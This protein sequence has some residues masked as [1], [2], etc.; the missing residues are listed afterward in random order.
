M[1]S[2][3]DNMKLKKNFKGIGDTNPVYTQRY[4]ADPWALVYDGRVYLYMTGD[5]YIYDEKGEIQENHYGNIDTLNVISSADLVNWTDHGCV[6]AAGKN[7][8]AT[9]GGN[10][11]APA[12]AC[13]E[14]DGK[15]KF[16]L[17]FANSGNGIAVL[18]ADSPVGPFTDPIGGPLISR[19]KTPTCDSVTWLFDP[20]VLLDDDGNAYIYF[21][22]GVPSDDMAALP[23]TA[24]VAK[25]GA[26]MISLDGD[27]IAIDNVEYLFEDSGINKI[28]GTYYYSYCSNFSIP[29]DQVPVT[30]FDQGEIILM[31]SD[32]P[33]GPF[34]KVGCVLKNPEHFTGLSGNNHHC[35][36]EFKGQLYMS[37]HTRILE[38]EQGILKGYRC[39]GLEPVNYKNGKFE[40]IQMTKS[41]VKQVENF[42]PF[43]ENPAACFAVMAD[44]HTTQFGEDAK[45][46]GSGE[47]I[48]TDITQGS[49]MGIYGVDFSEKVARSIAMDIRGSKELNVRICLDAPDGE[50]LSDV[51]FKPESQDEFG[52]V[53]AGLEKVA[54]GVHDVYFIFD[55]TDCEI[56]KWMME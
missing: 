49:F 13:K 36:F 22:G 42:N 3:F 41:G 43:K 33:M 56:R 47:M 54:T 29:K 8:Q 44:I 23:G 26:D 17:Y 30:G 9:W 12:A 27:P 21:G 38:R 39:T 45:K 18:T 34:T 10:S 28:D 32:K 35:M 55:E 25:L 53:K 46:Y 50:V 20:A 4:G 16:F 48:V 40:Q 24:R 31:S 2:I 19:E 15:M 52:V 37:Y 1:N 14:I 11:W 6:Y 7:G 51:C 5:D